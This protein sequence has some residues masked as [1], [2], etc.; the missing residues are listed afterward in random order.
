MERRNE[1][2][3]RATALWRVHPLRGASTV[4]VAAFLQFHPKSEHWGRSS[5]IP[6]RV[7][8]VD[9]RDEKDAGA[10]GKEEDGP[11]HLGEGD[12]LR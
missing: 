10:N 7:A 1:T 2:R 5:C 3:P 8:T 11:V 12:T 9:G 6:R 4:G